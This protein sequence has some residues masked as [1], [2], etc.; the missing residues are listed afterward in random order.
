MR[1]D[2]RKAELWTRAFPNRVWERGDR[3][4]ER[5]RRAG[6][7]LLELL[8]VLA[9]LVTVVSLTW[10]SVMRYLREQDIMEGAEATRTAAAG[11]RIKAIDT[12]LTYQFRYEPQGRRFVV[13]PYDPPET[14]A[15]SST[16]TDGSVSTFPVLSG[17][18][19]EECRFVTPADQPSVSEGLPP[20]AFAGLPNASELQ[21]TSWGPP[22]LFF[23]DGTAADA[24]FGITN[25]DELRIDLSVRGLTGTLTLGPLRQEAAQ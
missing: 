20:E 22:I 1:R 6:F 2:P 19:S 8:L 11:T 21:G 10:P 5:G 25:E 9:V 16:P 14:I 7:T 17:Q 3:C 18:L 13:V 24:T 4:A 15:A 23:P 12:G